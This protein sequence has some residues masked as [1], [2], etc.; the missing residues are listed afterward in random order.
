MLAAAGVDAS[1]VDGRPGAVRC[2]S[3]RTHRHAGSATQVR[4]A[5]APTWR[6][7]IT[8][9]AGRAWRNGQ[10]DL[11]IGCAGL[12]ALNDL[13]GATD[14][15]GNTLVVTAPATADEVASAADLVKGKL[16]GR[17]VAVLR[18]LGRPRP[19]CR[20]ARSRERPQL[21][22][23]SNEDLFGLGAR[24]AAVA[25]ALRTDPVALDHFPP[26]VAIDPAPFGGVVSERPDVRIEVTATE[27]GAWRVRLLLADDAPEVA[28]VHAGR[29]W[30][31]CAVL[32]AAHRLV[33]RTDEVAATAGEHDTAGWHGIASAVW[34]VG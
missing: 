2:P 13:S 18:G 31:R 19:P 16:A 34:F 28:A 1:N 9:T 30:E 33:A 23:P 11:A 6:S 4:G 5:P 26:R 12:P 24:E 32:A 14:G 10:I 15:Y 21:I 29:L 22:R 3:S 20:R 7:S 17:P 8:D 27:A 25:A